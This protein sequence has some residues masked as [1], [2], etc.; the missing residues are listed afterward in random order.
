M[1]LRPTINKPPAVSGLRKP[2][3]AAPAPAAGGLRRPVRQVPAT[4]APV[5][6]PSGFAQARAINKQRDE[7]FARQKLIPFRFRLKVG[8][9]AEVII[10][11]AQPYFCREH[12]WKASDGKWKNFEVCIMET[13][14]CPLCQKLG[15]EGSYNMML[16]CIDTRSYTDNNGK[17]HKNQRRLLVAKT[18]MIP[19]FER[20][21]VDQC[22]G[23]FRGARLKL[24]RDGQ[25]SSSIGDG[26]TFMGRVPEAKLAAL[27]DAAKP[28]PYTEAFK[29]LSQAEMAK[30]YNAM[31]SQVGAE[32]AEPAESLNDVD[33]DS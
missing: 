19:K 21:F 10:L 33:W 6:S 32:E 25:K 22:K 5:A 4:S 16:T 8:D 7:E 17:T 15:K 14:N 27:G 9:E 30:R 3:V 13:G 20:I 24:V 23:N 18:M 12:N 29:P 28:V 11:D 1:A 2:P 26:A 31:T